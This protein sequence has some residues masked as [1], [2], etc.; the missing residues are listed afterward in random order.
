MSF[1]SFGPVTVSWNGPPA[2]NGPIF[3]SHL[4]SAPAVAVAVLPFIATVTLAPAPPSPRP[5]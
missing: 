3:A 2:A 1:T 4:P 5:G